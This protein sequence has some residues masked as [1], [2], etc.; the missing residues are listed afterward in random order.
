MEKNIPGITGKVIDITQLLW[1]KRPTYLNIGRDIFESLNPEQADAMVGFIFDMIRTN[2]EV[3]L[4]VIDTDD[5][6]VAEK[7]I[8]ELTDEDMIFFKEINDIYLR[9][10][11]N[12]YFCRDD[13]DPNE[14]TITKETHICFRC[15]LK[16]GNFLEHVGI[17]REKIF[18]L[19][20][21]RKKD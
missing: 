14:E 21:M 4:G 15:Q 19:Q 9:A 20:G 2:V 18:K 10:H 1:N 17:P 3:G 12:C 13:V 6:P 16:L 7:A 11:G 8:E 5:N